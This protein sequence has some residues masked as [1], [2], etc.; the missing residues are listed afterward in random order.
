MKSLGFSEIDKEVGKCENMLC[1]LVPFM[2]SCMEE[3]A[4]QN[5]KWPME[6][7]KLLKENFKTIKKTLLEQKTRALE[8]LKEQQ[9]G[10]CLKNEK[11]AAELEKTYK[12]NARKIKESQV[13]LV[14]LHETFQQLE[15]FMKKRHGENS[16]NEK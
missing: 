15:A 12:E 10:S 1:G 6:H 3:M 2:T 13:G 8:K 9:D 16:L 4:V 7:N 11:E 5:R 14:E